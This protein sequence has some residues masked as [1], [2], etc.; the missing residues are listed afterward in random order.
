MIRAL[1]VA[2]TLTFATP[3]FAQGNATDQADTDALLGV[4]T[5]PDGTNAPQERDD[6]RMPTRTGLREPGLRQPLG[7][8]VARGV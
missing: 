3:A 1:L 6:Q 5:C 8:R 7:C 4:V 2:A